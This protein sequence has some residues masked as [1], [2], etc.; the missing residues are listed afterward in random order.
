MVFRESEGVGRMSPFVFKLFLVVFIGVGVI[1]N[2]RK[3]A[4][5]EHT[6][7]QKPGVHATA[8][9]IGTLIAIGVWLIF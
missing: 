2:I 3:A 7:M 8:A 4:K 1:L 5:G 9:V 6:E